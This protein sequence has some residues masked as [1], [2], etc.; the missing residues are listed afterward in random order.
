MFVELIATYLLNPQKHKRIFVQDKA[1]IIRD[2]R[3][4]Q[5]SIT[6]L[7]FQASHEGAQV[8]DSKR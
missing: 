8:I 1:D 2:D 5:Y 7:L 4:F 6:R 3:L